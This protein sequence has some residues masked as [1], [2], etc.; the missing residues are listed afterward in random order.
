MEEIDQMLASALTD[1]GY[2]VEFVY[3]GLNSENLA[4]VDGLVISSIYGISNDY[5]D[6]EINAISSWFGVGKFLWVAYDSDYAGYDYIRKNMTEI[7]SA[8]GSHVYGEPTSIEDPISNIQASYRAVATHTAEFIEDVDKVLMH[9]PT[10]L[11]GSTSANYDSDTV[12]LETTS[13][14]DV[15]PILWYSES[16]TIDD[17]D[18]SIPPY[19]HTDGSTGA[20]VAATYEEVHGGV[21]VVSGASP[22]GDYMPMCVEKYYDVLLDG[23]SFVTQVIEHG[24]TLSQNQ[25]PTTTTLPTDGNSN[26]FQLMSI[27]S[28]SITIGSV[29]VM[30]VF[31]VLIIRDKKS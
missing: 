15:H 8:V 13:I 23:L 27:V 20:F 10:C 1:M 31:A 19:V 17:Y 12:A 24:M 4:D 9:G 28:W 26:E 18:P 21:V 6:S 2:T 30:I 25:S 14:T 16:A 7:L 11:Y 5:T 29:V 22:Y 3:D